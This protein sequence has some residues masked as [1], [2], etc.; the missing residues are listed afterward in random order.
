MA[1][2]KSGW[3]VTHVFRGEASATKIVSKFGRPHPM[4]TDYYELSQLMSGAAHSEQYLLRRICVHHVIMGPNLYAHS[5]RS[6]YNV[7][8][9]ATLHAVHDDGECELRAIAGAET[10]SVT[11][12]RVVILI[13][14]TPDLRFLRGDLA[15]RVSGRL[16]P[17][18]PTS[19]TARKATHPVYVDVDPHSLQVLVDDSLFAW[20]PL[21]GDNFV[22]FLVGDSWPLVQKLHGIGGASNATERS[23]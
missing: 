3:H 11:A 21:R 16:D 22:R 23:Q 12:D 2:L 5:P 6:R 7:I 13:G 17:P 9:G 20:G 8:V 4:Y 19:A 15:D 14:S 1:A 10:V 18:D